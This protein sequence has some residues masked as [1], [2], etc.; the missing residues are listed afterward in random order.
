VGL[1][2]GCFYQLYRVR[3]T[4]NINA[5]TAERGPVEKPVIPTAAEFF[6]ALYRERRALRDSRVVRRIDFVQ[7]GYAMQ[8]R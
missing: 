3:N 2:S 6:A 8:K 5:F 1:V 4:P 7:F